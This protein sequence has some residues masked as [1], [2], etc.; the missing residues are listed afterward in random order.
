M[1]FNHVPS[2]LPINDVGGTRHDAKLC[3]TMVFSHPYRNED[4]P[5]FCGNVVNGIT[6]MKRRREVPASRNLK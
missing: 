5:D 6:C 1:P 2:T 4:S 3:G